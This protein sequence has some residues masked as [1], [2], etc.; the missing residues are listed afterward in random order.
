L[1]N[2]EQ[3]D[4]LICRLTKKQKRTMTNRQRELETY[5]QSDRRKGTETKKLR[6][7]QTPRQTKNKQTDRYAD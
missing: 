4:R 2:K 6:N 1:V 3:T 7:M 5:R